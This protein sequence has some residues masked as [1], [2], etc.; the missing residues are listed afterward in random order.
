MGGNKSKNSVVNETITNATMEFLN[1]NSTNQT[2]TVTATQDINLSPSGHGTI[3]DLEFNQNGVARA[4]TF[5]KLR[6]NVDMQTDLANKLTAALKEKKDE[7]PSVA[8]SDETNVRNTIK[9]TITQSFSNSNTTMNDAIVNLHQHID[10]APS[11]YGAVSH[12]VISQTGTAVAMLSSDITGGLITAFHEDNND[13]ATADIEKTN[14]ISTAF[15]S[16]AGL[17][18][19]PMFIIG[20]VIIVVIVIGA[21][22][23]SAANGESMGY[24]PLPLPFHP[25]Q[26]RKQNQQSR[27]NH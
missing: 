11:E 15:I 5:V 27:I 25:P 14:P 3:S 1:E 16:I 6:N 18:S 17:F 10:A 7:L 13:T 9:N 19:S 21:G 24:P 2:A 26:P 8:N 23:Y 22:L 12:V 4:Q 20:L